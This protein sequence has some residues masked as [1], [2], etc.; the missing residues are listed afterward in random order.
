MSLLKFYNTLTKKEEE[1]F[2]L[3][4]SAVSLYTC[5]PTVYDYAHTGNL[6]KYIFDDLLIRVLLINNYKVKHV[7][8]I[9]DIGHLVSDADEGEDKMMKALVRE[10]LQP[11]SDSLLELA[12]KY[13]RAFKRNIAALNIFSYTTNKNYTI[14]WAKATDHIKEQIKLIKKLQKKGYIYETSDG[15]YFDTAKLQDYGK[16]TGQNLNDLQEGARVEKNPEKKNPTDFVLW[17]K[18]TKKN[19]NH[20]MTWES[21]FGKGFPGWHIECSAMAMKYLGK[22][23]DIHTGGIDHIP[24]HHTNEI[25]QSEA[26]TGKPFSRFWLHSNFLTIRNEK[27]SKSKS[28]FATIEDLLKAGFSPMDYRYLCLTAHYRAPLAYSLEALEGAKN[29]R[30]K[31]I[32][33]L[34]KVKKRGQI[35][36]AE[37]QKFLKI[38]NQDLNTPQ[39]L[40]FVWQLLK[41]KKYPL[42]DITTTIL[43]CDEIFGLDLKL[44]WRQIK[45]DKKTKAPQEI[46]NLA[47]KRLKAKQN[48]NFETADNLREEINNQSW[49]IEDTKN[50]YILRKK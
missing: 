15:W 10:G 8:N 12:A 48:K 14:I 16:L 42:E 26:A 2:P 1:F 25:A 43:K 50:S 9:T 32:N 4:K 44:A 45:Q 3:K 17:V 39:A 20:V 24:V 46:I 33:E 18:A 37:W 41:N 30:L 31:L 7:I 11:N 22:T 19:K 34:T 6:R 40:A 47:E 13:T 28:G 21:P 5:G 49:E 23:L 29:S 36:E 27:M 38:I 35:I